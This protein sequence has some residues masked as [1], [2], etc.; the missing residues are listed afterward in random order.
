MKDKFKPVNIS[1]FLI[2][3]LLF[4]MLWVATGEA[5]EQRQSNDQNEVQGHIVGSDALGLGLSSPSFGAAIAQCV[6][7]EA[8]NFAFG[9]YGKQKVVVNYWCMG[10]SLYQMGH[11]DMAARVWCEKT[12]LGALYP[13]IGECINVASRPPET[14]VAAPVEVVSTP[15]DELEELHAAELE[16]QQMLLADLEAKIMNLQ[17]PQVRTII[18]EKERFTPEQAA[19]LREVV[20]E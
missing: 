5:Q 18:Q 7:T 2:A 17:Q 10:S 6:A 20:K 1:W 11:H 9:A 13:S 19:K 8:S 16:E 4:T 15:F 3:C 14:A 12:D